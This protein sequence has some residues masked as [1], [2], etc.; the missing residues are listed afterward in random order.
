MGRTRWPVLRV[1]A[2]LLSGSG[3]VLFKKPVANGSELRDWKNERGAGCKK[4]DHRDYGTERKFG[5]GWRD[6]RPYWRTLVPVYSEYCTLLRS[7]N[8]SKYGNLGDPPITPLPPPHPPLLYL[9]KP[10]INKVAWRKKE[11]RKQSNTHPAPVVT[12]WAEFQLISVLFQRSYLRGQEIVRVLQLQTRYKNNTFTS[13]F[14][15][16]KIL[17][18]NFLTTKRLF[19]VQW[20]LEQSG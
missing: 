8:T 12:C 5:S 1:P 15:E 20:Q 17:A 18:E 7:W 10:L 2:R 13:F 16:G 11:N 14:E 3:I 19:S 9:M 6:W 4:N